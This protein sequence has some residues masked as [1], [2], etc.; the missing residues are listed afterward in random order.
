M[1]LHIQKYAEHIQNAEFQNNTGLSVIKK[2]HKNSR[3]PYEYFRS[4]VHPCSGEE[5]C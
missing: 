2:F 3:H 4:K 5:K 1:Q